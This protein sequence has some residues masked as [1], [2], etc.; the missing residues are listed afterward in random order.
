MDA[1]FEIFGEAIGLDG[2]AND[3]QMVVKLALETRDV[4][5]V[6]DSFIEAPDEFRGDG[7]DGNLFVGNG[8]QD[9]EQF[10]GGLWI[11]CLIHGNLDD[12][13]VRAL[14]VA[15]VPVNFGGFVHGQQILACGGVSI[16]GGDGQGRV[17][18][19]ERVRA[20]QFFVAG[21]KGGDL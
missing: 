6:F 9:D 21:G 8:G 14:G 1:E 10:C 4:A 20:G 15:Y 19:A 7:L 11:V 12:K 2:E 5:D 16:G 17:H 3:R 18:S 13:I